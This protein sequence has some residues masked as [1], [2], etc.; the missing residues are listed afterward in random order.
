MTLLCCAPNRFKRIAKVYIS[1]MQISHILLFP[2]ITII[3]A[4]KCYTGGTIIKIVCRF[5]RCQAV[6]LKKKIPKPR[7]QSVNH[8]I[9]NNFF[10]AT[11][12]SNVPF[13]SENIK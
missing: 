7:N 6:Y 3:N 12:C 8:E 2:T 13:R 4:Q 1:F 5:V 10:Q 11:Y 9:K